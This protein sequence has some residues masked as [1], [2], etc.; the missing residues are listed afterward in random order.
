MKHLSRNDIEKLQL[1]L[2][3]MRARLLDEIQTAECDI[4]AAH[5]ALEGEVR[6]GSDASEVTRL[7][8][9]RRSEI[10]ADERQ[11]NAVAEAERRIDEGLYGVCIDCGNTIPV[12]RL[13]A[14]PT[15]V[16]CTSC[17]GSA[18]R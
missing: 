15:A 18:K 10:E 5:E 17:E 14:L 9:I 12:E 13:F 16:R 6:S 1:R 11:L 3:Q 8:E 4:E 2:S 7:E